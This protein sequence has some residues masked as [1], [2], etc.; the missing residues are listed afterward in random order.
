MREESRPGRESE[1]IA[2]HT[3]GNLAKII[4]SQLSHLLHLTDVIHAVPPCSSVLPIEEICILT[5]E[6]QVPSTA[7]DKSS[8]PQSI[9]ATPDYVTRHSVISACILLISCIPLAY[10]GED[11]STNT[12]SFLQSVYLLPRPPILCQAIQPV[13]V[14]VLAQNGVPAIADYSLS[15]YLI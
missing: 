4:P 12:T 7:I 10:S 15:C 3:T 9:G 14:S 2:F 5:R 11:G 1:A 6:M 13:W 8:C